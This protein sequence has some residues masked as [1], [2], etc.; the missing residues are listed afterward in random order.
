MATVVAMRF[1]V[2]DRGAA[3]PLD[4]VAEH[5]RHVER[6]GFRRFLVAE[7]H[8]VPGIPAGQPGMLAAH[9]VAHTQRIRVGTA[10]IMLL[11]HPPFL[12]AEQI[13]LLE[14]LYPGRID[15]GIGSSV[16][17]TGPVRRALRQGNPAEVKQRFETELETLLRY[18]RGEEAVTVRPEYAGTPI[19]VLAGF[20]SAMVAAKM[21]PRGCIG[22]MRLPTP[23]LSSPRSILPLPIRPRPPVICC[24]RRPMP[25]HS[26]NL[27]AS[28][29]PCGLQES[30]TWMRSRGSSAGALRR[31]WPMTYGER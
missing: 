6:L 14:A 16:G 13:N 1:S 9:V 2:L 3:S 25:R 23:H 20:R 28:S 18:L 29:R 26:R 8:G 30:W 21:T 27:P 4:Q 12:V 10:G 31:R 15:I 17:F 22:S 19:Y 11:N 7:H 5:A 24:Y